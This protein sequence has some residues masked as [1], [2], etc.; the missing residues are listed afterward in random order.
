MIHHT[1]MRGNFNFR[2]HTYKRCYS[3][4]L[5]MQVYRDDFCLVHSE[6]HVQY[7]VLRVSRVE[8]IV[9]RWVHIYLFCAVYLH[10]CLFVCLPVIYLVCAEKCLNLHTD[11][12]VCLI[13]NL[14]AHW[15]PIPHAWLWQS[16]LFAYWLW[17][18]VV[19]VL[20]LLTKY[21][22]PRGV[23]LLNYFLQPRG[24]TSACWKY[25][26]D[27]RSISLAATIRPPLSSHTPHPSNGAGSGVPIPI[28]YL[29]KQ[30]C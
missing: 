22:R 6:R 28:Y 13:L 26:T 29:C 7:I 21:W 1:H 25:P 10:I 8:V 14:S 18:C 12:G 9:S 15:R 19:T 30:K 16:S 2:L 11:I 3:S 5:Q 23:T 24:I 27:G 20:I 4:K 17:S